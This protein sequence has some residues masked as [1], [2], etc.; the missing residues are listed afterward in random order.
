M[1]TTDTTAIQIYDTLQR[2]FRKGVARPLGYRKHQL[3]QLARLLKENKEAILAAEHADLGKP[4]QECLVGEI[5][6]M[7]DR[8]IKSAE[9]L[10]EWS[11][12]QNVE[13][14]EWQKTWSPTVFSIPKGVVLIIS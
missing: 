11:K 14:P 5:G 12:P 7:M 8:S 13:V 1:P 10:E 3:Y 2:S 9:L 6:A 4:A